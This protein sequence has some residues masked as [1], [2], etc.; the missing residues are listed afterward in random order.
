MAAM[1]AELVVEHVYKDFSTQP[2]GSGLT[3][4]TDASIRVAAGEFVCILGPSGCGKSTLLNIIAGFEKAS[5]GSVS[6]GGIPVTSASA[7]RT[8]VFQDYALFPWKTIAENI[9]F[10]L[11]AKGIALAERRRIAAKYIEMVHLQGFEDRY[12][13]QVSGGMKQRAAVARA[14]AHDPAIILMD[15][16]FGAL[17]QQTRDLLQ[18][19]VLKIWTETKKT[20]VLVTHSIDEAVFLSDRVVIMTARPGRIKEIVPIDLPRPRLAA[21]RNKSSFIKLRSALWESVREESDKQRAAASLTIDG[22]RMQLVG[23]TEE[24]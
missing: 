1:N 20:I 22:R 24:P 8:M 13:H 23:R 19:E 21:M 17:D 12:P 16:P 10:G 9:Q 11:K 3:V 5:R 15:E 2:F 14:L 18:E 6:L 7:E 4:V